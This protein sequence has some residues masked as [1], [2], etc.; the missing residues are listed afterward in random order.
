MKTA[1]QTNRRGF[2][3]PRLKSITRALALVQSL[4]VILA[5]LAAIAQIQPIATTN[6]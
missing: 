5:A 2:I 6:I 1:N 4:A 3:F